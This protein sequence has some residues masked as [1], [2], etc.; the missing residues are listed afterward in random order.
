MGER[1]LENYLILDSFPNIFLRNS[2]TLLRAYLR[3][4]YVP[5]VE[6]VSFILSFFPPPLR[7]FI[8]AKTTVV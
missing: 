7:V 8:E 5:E 2:S 3:H 4:F 1:R 6:R